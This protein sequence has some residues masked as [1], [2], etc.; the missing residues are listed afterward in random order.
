MVFQKKGEKVASNA[1]QSFNQSSNNMG[2][3]IVWCKKGVRIAWVHPSYAGQT[4]S[5][6]VV[7]ECACWLLDEKESTNYETVL[8]SVEYVRVSFR[9][10]NFCHHCA[11]RHGE[12]VILISFFSWFFMVK[13]MW[14]IL[15]TTSFSVVEGSDQWPVAS[16]ASE[17]NEDSFNVSMHRQMV[18]MENRCVSSDFPTNVS[19]TAAKP[20]HALSGAGQWTGRWKM[21][22]LWAVEPL[23]LIVF[24]FQKAIHE[25]ISR[26][27]MF[28]R[29]AAVPHHGQKWTCEIITGPFRGQVLCHPLIDPTSV[30]FTN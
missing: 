25:R 18:R 16:E 22:S 29:L 2:A 8:S 1:H 11:P 15:S 7:V 6:L 20:V 26:R 17:A 24:R 10:E 9:K 19:R 28:P 21:P 30:P 27:C 5:T 4:R 12:I 23:A 14:L 13:N 3:R